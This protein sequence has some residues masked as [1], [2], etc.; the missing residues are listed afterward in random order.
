ML[1]SASSYT[2]NILDAACAEDFLL[3]AHE[4][5]TEIEPGKTLVESWHNHHLAWLLGEVAAGRERRVIINIPPRAL[6]SLLVSVI[7]VAFLL[8]RNPTLKVIVASHTAELARTHAANFRRLIDSELFRRVFPTF[9]LAPDGDRLFTQKTTANGYRKATSVG[10]TITGHGADLIIL[11]DPN[12]AKDISSVTHRA[13]VNA[14]YDQELFTRLNDKSRG[15]VLVVM[16]RLHEDDLTGHLLARGKWTHT[17]IPARATEDLAFR[18]GPDDDDVFVRPA[19]D[20]LL[21]TFNNEDTLEDLRA[22][23]GSLSFEAQYQQNP[24]PLDGAVIKRAW[25][26]YYE[27]P[28]DDFD[29]ILCSWDLASTIEEESDYSVGTVWGRK[30]REFYLLDVIRGRYEAPDLRRKIEQTHIDWRAHATIIEK[31]GIGDAIGAEMRR[32]SRIRP[33]LIKVRVDKQSRLI[34]ESPKFEAGQVLLPRDAGWLGE[35]VVE[36]L[37]F[38]AGRNDDQVDSTSQAL[39]YLTG[40]MMQ[41]PK[42]QLDQS[43]Q[44]PSP[45]RPPGRAFRKS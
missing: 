41:S 24:V 42:V 10:A 1:L 31:A 33:L 40:K 43:G 15:Q 5:F 27:R 4:A 38:P 34:A 26:R 30:G 18:V 19:G 45:V 28:P 11:D 7:F 17:V 44:R 37:A 25:L 39:R 8:G 14:Y 29:F 13:K 9:Q 36:L 12:R 21:P 20:I 6:K 35:Y 2:Q 16:Q 23:L 32:Q 3:F 22:T